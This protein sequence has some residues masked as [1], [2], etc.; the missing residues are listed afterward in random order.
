MA[1]F[2][3]RI[4]VSLLPDDVAE[5]RRRS[6]QGQA[7]IGLVG[8]PVVRAPRSARCSPRHGGHPAIR[9]AWKHKGPA[10]RLK[11]LGEFNDILRTRTGDGPNPRA[12]SRIGKSPASVRV[13]N[14]SRRKWE[15]PG[16][17]PRGIHEFAE[18]DEDASLQDAQLWERARIA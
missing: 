1:W 6:L 13:V 8:Y 5:H 14:V 12:L 18:L 2:S 10:F 16:P 4:L 3:L 15:P 11:G 9:L 7:N 17:V